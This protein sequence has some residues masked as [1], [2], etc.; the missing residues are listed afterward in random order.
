[1]AISSPKV[2]GNNLEEKTSE[3]AKQANN[4]Q[5]RKYINCQELAEKEPATRPIT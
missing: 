1:L 2:I 3:P 4:E 5:V